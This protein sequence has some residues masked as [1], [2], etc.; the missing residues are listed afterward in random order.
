MRRS[1]ILLAALC[2][3]VAGCA[4]HAVVRPPVAPPPPL[5]TPPAPP[6]P[7]L[8]AHLEG[9]WENHETGRA[10]KE[11]TF[12][13]NGTLTFHGGFEF[14]NPGQWSLDSARQTLLITLPNA[15]VDRLHAFQLSVG[16]GVQAFDP[17]RKQITYHF[18]EQTWSLN[19]AGWTYTKTEVPVIKAAPQP[20]LD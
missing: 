14:F 6:P 2:A 16:D 19:I 8:R 3:V 10:G 15:D 18:D 9:L 11:L 5:P 12:A 1:T 20:P 4:P 13:P 7:D 17:V